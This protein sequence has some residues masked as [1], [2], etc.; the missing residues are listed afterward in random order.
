MIS[1]LDS[2]GAGDAQALLLPARER[3]AALAE[4]ILDFIPQS[5]R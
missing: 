3:Q 5:L 2:D 1:G 4:L